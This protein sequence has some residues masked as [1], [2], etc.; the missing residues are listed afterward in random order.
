MH[1]TTN[2]LTEN[3]IAKK[4]ANNALYVRSGA[5]NYFLRPSGFVAMSFGY[6]FL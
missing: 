6:S 3:L 4:V 5:F 1:I 2:L